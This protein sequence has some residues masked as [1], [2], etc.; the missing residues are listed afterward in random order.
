MPSTK[1]PTT[2]GSLVLLAASSTLHL[3]WTD[4]A[5]AFA[6]FGAEACSDLVATPQRF[7]RHRDGNITYRISNNFI[8]RYPDL[9]SQYLV[10]DVVQWWE[11]Y[12]NSGYT[13]SDDIAS[14]FSYFRQ[15]PDKSV[16]ELKSVLN[17]EFGHA[18]GM[19][20]SDACFY[21][22]NGD[23]GLP[24]ESNHRTAGGGALQV[25]PTIGP[26][27]MN[28]GWTYASP[29]M[30]APAVINGYNRLPGRD[31][32]EFLNH[33]YPFQTLNFNQIDAGSPVIL[34]DSTDVASSGGQTTFP[35]GTTAIVPGD[36][37]Q[38]HYLDGVNIWIGNNIGYQNKATWW[39]IA[40]NTGS[41][42]TQITLRIAGS[43]TRRAIWDDAPNEFSSFGVSTTSSPEIMRY[44]WSTSFDSGLWT[45]GSSDNFALNLDVHDWVP[46]EALMWHYSNDAWPIPLPGLVADSPWGYATPQTPPPGSEPGYT[47][48]ATNPEP[49]VEPTQIELLPDLQTRPSRSRGLTV[50]LPNLDGLRIQRIALLPL[51][52]TQAEI[53]MRDPF[54]RQR[55]QLERAFEDG[56]RHII[57]LITPSDAGTKAARLGFKAHESGFPYTRTSDQTHR[58][59]NDLLRGRFP[60]RLGDDTT[61]AALIRTT[62]G[63]VSTTLLALP[64]MTGYLGTRV[65]R[66]HR[67]DDA[68][69][70][71]PYGARITRGGPAAD[72][73][74]ASGPSACLLGKGGDDILEIRG[75]QPQIVAAGDGSDQVL[76]FAADAVVSLGRGDDR[77]VAT[78]FAA[79]SV[80]GGAGDDKIE[81]SDLSDSLNGGAGADDIDG[82]GGDDL[83]IGE[84]DADSLHGGPGNDTLLPGSGADYVNGGKGD[85]RVVINHVCELDA[86]KILKGGS[87]QDTLVLPGSL[88]QARARG[89]QASG[90]ETVV[91]FASRD[92]RIADCEL[93]SAGHAAHRT[94]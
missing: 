94:E 21:N 12:I 42:I 81:G 51:N 28:E 93:R 24:W 69:S 89:L 45:D 26:E 91:E 36:G 66:C 33:A 77:F 19:Q 32:W 34:F 50:T 90:F 41:D 25:Q 59:A 7:R 17:H 48:V 68:G 44:T 52:W 15:D 85:D 9:H 76:A 2:L 79:A 63:K 27:L 13:W 88:E 72:R 3:T 22:T 55:E 71:C 92:S 87:G 60:V 74:T 14:R 16:Y 30:K 5:H 10:T 78:R 1:L 49:S 53:I 8:D 6:G 38:G 86:A 4:T 20:H 61:Y 46:T 64:E 23:T 56:G 65:A 62:T 70:C 80:A 11:D 75:S 82:A 58:P 47:V 73:L 43:S 83:I 18:V 57:E 31:D 40:N 39:S 84:A 37:D 54:S 67:A 29:G 35:G